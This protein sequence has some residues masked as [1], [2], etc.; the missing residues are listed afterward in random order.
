MASF[1]QYSFSIVAMHTYE[2]FVLLPKGIYEDCLKTFNFTSM[3]KEE[4]NVLQN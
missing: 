3:E 1:A 2:R 4:C